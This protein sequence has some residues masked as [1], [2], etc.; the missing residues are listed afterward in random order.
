M[1]IFSKAY[2]SKFIKSYLFFS[3]VLLN[4]LLVSL[5]GFGVYKLVNLGVGYDV[6]AGKVAD[7]VEHRVPWVSAVIRTATQSTLPD[8][9][10]D[11]VSLDQWRGKGASD[12]AQTEYSNT[13]APSVRRVST[14]SEF[15]TALN[16]VQAGTKI[17]LEKGVYRIASR[18]IRLKHDGASYAPIVVTAEKLGDAVLELD[19]LEGFYVDKSYWSFQNLKIVGVCQSHDQCEHAFHVVGSGNHVIIRNNVVTDFNA[20]IKVNPI[21]QNGVQQV[22]DDGVIEG[23]SFF[24]HSVRDT[25][26]PVTLLDIIAVNDWVVRDNL[27][28]DFVKGGGNKV[29]YAAFFKGNGSRNLFERNLVACRVKQNQKGGA[30]VGLSFGGG[31][32]DA[33]VCRDG[34]CD[35]EHTAGTIRHNVIMHCDDVGIYL[36]KSKNTEIYNNTLINTLGIDIRYSQSSAVLAN[37]VVTGRIK[38]RDGGQSQEVSNFVFDVDDVGDVFEG[39][40]SGDFRLIDK[41]DIVDQGV[42]LQ[43]IEQDFCGINRGLAKV[44]I[45]AFEYADGKAACNPFEMH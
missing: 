26:N 29:S 36:N 17:I 40:F 37:N 11:E 6:I 31:G 42:D 20:H 14:A 33:S 19:T 13:I 28:A 45:G 30:Q 32:T 44:D 12:L 7:K 23:N 27:I 3:G 39:A 41:D 1:N 34:K 15:L 43:E 38:D 9:M 35:V 18:N 10:L 24:N 16:E 25:S 5:L 22:P 4:L 2:L 8:Y 21:T